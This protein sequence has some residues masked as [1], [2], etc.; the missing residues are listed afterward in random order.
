MSLP[1]LLGAI[2]VDREDRKKGLR[3]RKKMG[4]HKLT[5]ANEKSLFINGDR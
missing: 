2:S 1:L 4:R 3:C 5:G